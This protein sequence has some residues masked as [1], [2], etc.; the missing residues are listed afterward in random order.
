MTLYLVAM[1]KKQ[2]HCEIKPVFSQTIKCL[3]AISA[4]QK[5]DPQIKMQNYIVM[6][7]YEQMIIRMIK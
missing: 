4:T 7:N 2:L 1:E 6:M 5:P 3:Y